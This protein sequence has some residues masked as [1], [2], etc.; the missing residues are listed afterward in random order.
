MKKERRKAQSATIN[1]DV[2]EKNMRLCAAVMSAGALGAL[3]CLALGCAFDPA[4][5]MLI[6]NV[7]ACLIMAVY[8]HYSNRFSQT[9]SAAVTAGF[10]GALSVFAGISRCCVRALENANYDL[11]IINLAANFG[12]CL[13]VMIIAGLFLAGWK[14][15]N[16]GGKK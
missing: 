11:L 12:L 10:C 9:A 14:T 5:N 1:T 2:K 7:S 3:G 6:C 15:K 8:A 13:A 4:T 16:K